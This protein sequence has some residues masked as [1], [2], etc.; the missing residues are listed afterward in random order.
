M[1]SYMECIPQI[2]HSDNINFE[3]KMFTLSHA[4]Q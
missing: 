1:L 2:C 4:F 3:E